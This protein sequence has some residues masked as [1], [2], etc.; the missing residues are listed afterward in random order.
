MVYS[1]AWIY[2]HD[3]LSSLRYI[4]VNRSGIKIG[5]ASVGVVTT[6]PPW[7]LDLHNSIMGCPFTEE[8]AVQNTCL[9]CARMPAF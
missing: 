6:D 9:R 7:L 5:D 4:N 3:G 8:A 2:L 1:D